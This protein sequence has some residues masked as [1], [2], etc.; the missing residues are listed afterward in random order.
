MKRGDHLYIYYAFLGINYTH[1]CIYLGNSKIIHYYKEKIQC[2][3]LSK[4]GGKS[5]IHVKE[6][7]KCDSK[8][9]VI[10]RAKSRR[11]ER[12]YNPIFNNCEHFVYWCKTGKH[13]S[14]Q[15]EDAPKKLLK[16]LDKKF[17]EA[18]KVK[19]PKRV[20]VKFRGS[21]KVKPPKIRCKAP[22]V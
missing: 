13:K 8:S 3:S 2:T 12:L 9:V 11:G 15:L 1:H 21:L 7:K 10:R 14:K 17:K 22:F 19:V 6:Y 16:E 20:K 18:V 5:K 4:F